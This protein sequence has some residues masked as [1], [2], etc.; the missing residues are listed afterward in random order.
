MDVIL[1][2]VTYWKGT[3]IKID[4]YEF[5]ECII[6]IFN[7]NILSQRFRLYFI[8]GDT[9]KMKEKRYILILVLIVYNNPIYM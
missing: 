1:W 7:L 4:L 9:E 6:I 2:L 3:K 5:D 8:I